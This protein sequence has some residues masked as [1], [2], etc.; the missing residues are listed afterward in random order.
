MRRQIA[1]PI[2]LW[3]IA[4]SLAVASGVALA[5][6]GGGGGGGG[7]IVGLILL[8][9][10]IIYSAILSYIVSKKSR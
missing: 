1:H 8:P 6:A 10:V 3:I 7:G 2:I 4:L 5:R 9:F